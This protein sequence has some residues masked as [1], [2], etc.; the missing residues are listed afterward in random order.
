ML[1]P[2]T[3]SVRR[4]LK[5]DCA[6]VVLVGSVVSSTVVSNG[7]YVVSMV[8]SPGAVVSHGS[9]VV[10]SPPSPWARMRPV[11]K[12]GAVRA[13]EEARDLLTKQRRF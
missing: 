9:V 6:V 10:V 13:A 5:A 12:A 11:K 3:G 7:S 4:I 2:A 1:S 8:V